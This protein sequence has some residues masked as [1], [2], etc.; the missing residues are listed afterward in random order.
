M[1]LNPFIP[2]WFIISKVINFL[3]YEYPPFFNRWDI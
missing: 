1:L 3:Y 2:F